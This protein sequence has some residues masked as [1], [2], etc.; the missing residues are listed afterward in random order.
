MVIHL[1]TQIFHLNAY[2]RGRTT[3]LTPLKSHLLQV[4]EPQ[5]LVGDH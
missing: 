2:L 4:V 1:N 5:W 3:H